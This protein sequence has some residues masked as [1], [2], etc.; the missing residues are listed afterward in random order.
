MKAGPPNSL[1]TFPIR[2]NIPLPLP[3]PRPFLANYLKNPKIP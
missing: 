1:I 3:N 2:P